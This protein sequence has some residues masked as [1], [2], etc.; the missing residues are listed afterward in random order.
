MMVV[1]SQPI[2]EEGD[3][4]SANQTKGGFCFVQSEKRWI[5]PKPIT[6]E[7]DVPQASQRKE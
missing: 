5:F 4:P 3:L 1:F 7:A 2:R 6:E